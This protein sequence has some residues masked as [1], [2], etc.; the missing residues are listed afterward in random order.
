MHHRQH[1]RCSVKSIQDALLVICAYG[2][3]KT[4]ITI[5]ESLMTYIIITPQNKQEYAQ[6]E[7]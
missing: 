1:V 5:L 3:Q 2:V 4:G 6:Q 7:Y